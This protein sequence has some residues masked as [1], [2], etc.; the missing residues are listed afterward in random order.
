MIFP[1][2]LE[3][4]SYTLMLMNVFCLSL[5]KFY[6]NKSSQFK[7]YAAIIAI[8]I[9]NLTI[10][11]GKSG[12]KDELMIYQ[13]FSFLLLTKFEIPM[14]RNKLLF[15]LMLLK[16]I[17]VWFFHNTSIRSQNMPSYVAILNALIGCF[18]LCNISN[19]SRHTQSIEKF[20]LTKK[21]E[22]SEDQLKII[23]QSSSDGV[24]IISKMTREIEFWNSNTLSLLNCRSED[25]QISL[26]HY[27]YSLDKRMSGFTNN[28][29]FLIDDIEFALCDI[30]DQEKTLGI[31]LLENVSL[32]WK[33]QK[34]M[35]QKHESL[36]IRMRN[37]TNIVELE[38]SITTDKMKT[39]LLRS[40]SHELRTPLNAIIF[41]TDE[42]MNK[43]SNEE[44]IDED[45]K[46]K[47][48]SVSAKLMLSL[49]NDLLDYSKILSG[50]FSI[51][52]NYCDLG[53]IIHDACEL[54][55]LQAFK[56][57]ILLVTRID[58][59]IPNLIYTD[60]L[61]LSQVILNLLS[62]AM[63]FTIIG[64]IEISCIMNLKNRLKIYVEDTGIGLEEETKNKLFTEFCTSNLPKINPQ[65]SGLGLC[66]SNFL[67]KNLGNK[68]IKAF[69]SAGKGSTF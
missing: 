60:P 32:E 2:S 12:E 33:I 10:L 28:S 35:W 41:F 49:I 11:Y 37:V 20:L 22:E 64:K 34:V 69:S 36:F 19:Y 27:Q 55:R 38:K 47:I 23:T 6:E 1:S 59:E 25:I 57:N 45:R 24:I 7:V 8:E 30:P 56:K 53:T 4:F 63:K 61:R 39:V 44:V 52:K 51:N 29:N 65:G 50:V 14:I 13:V 21:L 48:I 40:V 16:H 68:P 3:N 66:I 43:H 46:L 62:N 42:L 15:N 5:V 54:I 31:T 26:S 9:H 58:P 67:V 17:Y 18:M